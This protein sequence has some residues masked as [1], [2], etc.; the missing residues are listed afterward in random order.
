M[1][2]YGGDKSTEYVFQNDMAAPAHTVKRHRG[3]CF[4]GMIG[5]TPPRTVVVRGGRAS[6][7]QP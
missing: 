2:H 5:V 4:R 1:A 6:I 7:R 3:P